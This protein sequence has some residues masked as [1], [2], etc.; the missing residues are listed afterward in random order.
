MTDRIRFIVVP[1]LGFVVTVLPPER[2]ARSRPSDGRP[3]EPN[4]KR[5]PEPSR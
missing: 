3:P 2:T 1:L 5:R 4:W